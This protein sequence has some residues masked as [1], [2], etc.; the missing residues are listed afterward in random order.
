MVTH[1]LVNLVW[2]GK[3]RCIHAL[4]AHLPGFR[5]VRDHVKENKTK[6]KTEK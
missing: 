2:G 6:R 3:D 5:L 4:L 1:T